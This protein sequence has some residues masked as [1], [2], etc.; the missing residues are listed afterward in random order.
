ME[1]LAYSP[2][3]IRN[4]DRKIDGLLNRYAIPFESDRLLGDLIDR[5]K[6]E[7]NF[8]AKLVRAY[9]DPSYVWE[10]NFEEFSVPVLIDYLQRSHRYYLEDRLPN[11]GQYIFLLST[12][13]PKGHP[14]IKAMSDF[15]TPYCAHL[16]QHIREEENNLFP[17]ALD[18]YANVQ[19][20]ARQPSILMSA[21]SV[22]DFADHHDDT[23]DVLRKFRK[24]LMAFEPCPMTETPYRILSNLLR[25]FEQD[26]EIHALIE[27]KVLVPK[28]WTLETQWAG[29]R[30][31][32]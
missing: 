5:E 2:Q 30:S 14:L 23:E 24:V 32:K 26:L 17:Y 13:Y 27:D 8:F 31:V 28:L 22:L 1:A 21:Y 11:I 19:V 3:E 9:I 18:L 10:E 4:I 7:A 20:G 12:N 16:S 6:I 25:H 29:Q 15:F